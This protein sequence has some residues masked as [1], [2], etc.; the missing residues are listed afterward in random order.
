VRYFTGD[1]ASAA[2][3]GRCICGRGFP[4]LGHIEGRSKECL[5]TPSGKVIGPAVLGHYLF[6]Y[7]AHLES[8]RHYQLV[9]DSDD[10]V[11][12]LV[13]PSS[14]WSAETG[15]VLAEALDKLL[16]GELH[17]SVQTVADIPAEPSGKRPIIKARGSQPHRAKK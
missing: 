3:E 12:L 4:K 2:P 5:Y 16:G 9:Q 15:G 6:V 11:R 8:V 1:L 17:V 13:V 10:S 7:N 14:H